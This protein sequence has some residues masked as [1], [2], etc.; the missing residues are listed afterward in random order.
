MSRAQRTKGRRGEREALALL[1]EYG[2]EG[3]LRYGQEERGGSLGDIETTIGNVEVKRRAKVPDWLTPADA[4][5][6]VLVRQDRGPWLAVM[7]ASDVLPRLVAREGEWLI[8]SGDINPD[9]R[10]ENERLQARIAELEAEKADELR[11]PYYVRRDEAGY[12]CAIDRAGWTVLQLNPGTVRNEEYVERVVRLL[13]RASLM[14][15]GA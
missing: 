3:E 12:A 6:L 13:N 15:A 1:A 10:A 5:R 9:V 11:R 4:V 2:I 7:R 8:V 14:P